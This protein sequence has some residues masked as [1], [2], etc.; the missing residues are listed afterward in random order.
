MEGCRS[1]SNPST[2]TVVCPRRGL[3]RDG[4]LYPCRSPENCVSTSSIRT[5]EKLGTPWEYSSQTNDADKAFA[6]LIAAVEGTKGVSLKEIDTSSRYLWAEFPSKVPQDG[7]DDVEFLL[8]PSDNMVLYRS[9]SRRTIFVYPLQRP[10]SDQGN[11]KERLEGG[12]HR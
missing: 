3:T 6:S 9:A 8:K 12:L 7:V 2:T 5:P 11:N 1:V 4:R 10:L